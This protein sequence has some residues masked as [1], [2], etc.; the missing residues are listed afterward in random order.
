MNN[1]D[2]VILLIDTSTERFSLAII[3]N[4]EVVSEYLE[5]EKQSHAKKITT[6]IEKILKGAKK[7]F[8]DLNAIAINE[9]PGSFT[10]LRVASSCAKGLCFSLNIPLISIRGIEEY[11]KTALLNQSNEFTECMILINARRQNYFYAHI[12]N[13]EIVKKISFLDFEN[14]M[15]S[16][17]N[18][19]KTFVLKSEDEF[20]YNYAIAK[21]LK[22]KAIEKFKNSDFEDLQTFEPNYHLNT[23]ISK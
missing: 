12:K 22:N 3:V 19:E 21:N 20:F 1:K 6:A 4:N 2:N 15:K 7:S 8:K 13:G 11:A 16:V 14:I 23:Y 18:P 17:E 9:G 5:I 10:G